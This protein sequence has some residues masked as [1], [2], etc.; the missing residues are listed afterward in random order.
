MFLC[1]M[2]AVDGSVEDLIKYRMLIVMKQVY[3]RKSFL[4]PPILFGP[5]H[6]YSTQ[7]LST[8]ANTDRC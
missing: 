5:Q 8:Y 7:Y 2:Q 4:E 3:H 6:T 1:I